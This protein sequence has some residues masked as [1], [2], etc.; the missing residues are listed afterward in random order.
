MVI[1]DAGRVVRTC[2]AAHPFRGRPVT[3]GFDEYA[4]R[5]IKRM[6]GAARQLEHGAALTT[7]AIAE[8]DMDS[9]AITTEL[10]PSASAFLAFRSGDPE[11]PTAEDPAD[12][13]PRA[14]YT[15][16]ED[17]PRE[18]RARQAA[19]ALR[20]QLAGLTPEQARDELDGHAT[21]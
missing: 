17:D 15:R 8:D 1:E 9:T 21:R 19:A 5:G 12:L 13:D 14:S 7:F 11:S 18:P 20:E 16:P 6:L 4:F 2:A 10:A 3:G